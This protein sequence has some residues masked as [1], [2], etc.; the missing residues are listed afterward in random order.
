M[1]Q[2]YVCKFFV[3]S[4]IEVTVTAKNK[5]EARTKAI[6]KAILEQPLVSWELD[7][8]NEFSIEKE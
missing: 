4:D 5:E 8:E 7:E 6:K 2:K 3:W 1:A